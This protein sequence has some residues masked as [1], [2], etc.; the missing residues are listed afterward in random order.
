MLGGA[1]E[2]ILGLL[3]GCFGSRKLKKLAVGRPS[4]AVLGH[5][6]AI[7][8][9]KSILEPSEGHFWCCYTVRYHI[10]LLGDAPELTFGLL[11]GVLAV[12]ISKKLA[13][14]RPSDAVLGLYGA[15][16]AQKHNVLFFYF[17]PS[18]SPSG[19]PYQA[20]TLVSSFPFLASE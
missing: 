5:G 16:L 8:A 20:N 7:L 1:S 3:A 19:T 2:L 11:A 17:S 10:G 13:V 15:I 14:G 6:S 9:Q 4:E 18:A 12:G